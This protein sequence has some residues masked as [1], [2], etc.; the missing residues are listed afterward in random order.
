MA[1]TDILPREDIRCLREELDAI[2]CDGADYEEVEDLLLD[3]GLEM[4]YL[5]DLI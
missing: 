2:L 4:D 1:L 5:F 3:Y